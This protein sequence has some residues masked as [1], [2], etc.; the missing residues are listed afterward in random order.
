MPGRRCGQW[1]IKGNRMRDLGFLLGLSVTSVCGL[2]VKWNMA[3]GY[4]WTDGFGL[5]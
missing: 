4:D 3:W 2:G 1:D 5:P